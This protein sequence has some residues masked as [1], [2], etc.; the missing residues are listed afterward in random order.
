MYL[1]KAL[2]IIR[3]EEEP[4]SP[5][6][7]AIKAAESAAGADG[8]AAVKQEEAE[9]VDAE[10]KKTVP[11]LKFQETINLIWSNCV[12]YNGQKAAISF[13]AKKLKKI[14]TVFRRTQ[15]NHDSDLNYS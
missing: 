11:A 2:K 8:K 3:G 4:P 6:L 9:G 10:G 15:P 5:V 14:F 13:T 1:T 7:D 12:L